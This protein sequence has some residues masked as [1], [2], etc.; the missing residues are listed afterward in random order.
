M[1]VF[2]GS[3]FMAADKPWDTEILIFSSFCSPQTDFK[4]GKGRYFTIYP[5]K[6]MYYEEEKCLNTKLKYVLY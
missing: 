2:L 3:V 5:F 6:K 1:D 4:T